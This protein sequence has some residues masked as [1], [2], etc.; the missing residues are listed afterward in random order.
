MST[1]GTTNQIISIYFVDKAAQELDMQQQ[2]KTELLFEVNECDIPCDRITWS[3]KK[4]HCE[5]TSHLIC[6]ES[7]TTKFYHFDIFY[8]KNSGIHF[9]SRVCSTSTSNKNWNHFLFDGIESNILF[10]IFI[11]KRYIDDHWL[12][13]QSPFSYQFWTRNL[14]NDSQVTHT[15]SSTLQF[16]SS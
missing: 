16:H 13:T 14:C 11:Q 3:E 1:L 5:F 4:K 2:Q 15:K 12:Q 10:D 7:W 8:L 9:L 6:V